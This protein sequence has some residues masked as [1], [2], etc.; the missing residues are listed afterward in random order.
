M[1]SFEIN[2]I[3]TK[4]GYKKF[5]LT[6]LKIH[7]DNCVVDEVGAEYNENGIT[8]LKQ[9]CELAKETLIDS[10]VTVEF[11]DDTETDILGHGETGEYKDGIPL[12]SNAKTIGHFKQV[13]I[14][15]IEDKDG[16]IITVLIGEGLLDYMRYP[17]C[18]DELQRKLE[19]NETVYGSVEIVRPKDSKF[20]NYLYGYKEKGRIPV[21]FEFSGYAILGCGVAPA[22]STASIIELSSKKDKDKEIN[23]MDEKTLSIIIAN[24]VKEAVIEANNKNEVFE[25]K[26]T[27][28]NSELQ[29][30]TNE[31]C[32]LTDRVNQ[33]HK[34]L[35]EIKKE[36]ETSWAEREAIENELAQIKVAQRISELN[37]KLNS[38]TDEQKN[39]AKD[40]I[41]TFNVD[42]TKYEVNYIISKIH[43]GIGKATL[44]ANAK[45]KLSEQNSKNDFA[46]DIFSDVN[47]T[48]SNDVN[49]YSSLFQ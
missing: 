37:E 4:T 12:L 41:E 9:Y 49:D 38:F 48:N 22:D 43:A 7:P 20:I 3:E 34:A 6:L 45:K 26:I 21:G 16:N 35:E 30:K 15:E 2:A 31:N 36:Q 40:E 11:A 5:K 42:P 46:V 17:N 29:K 19:N 1:R 23:K 33:L 44:E 27:E 8:W 14:D 28:L 32:D 24:S 39:Y 18:I 47:E 13:Y 25:K 10:S